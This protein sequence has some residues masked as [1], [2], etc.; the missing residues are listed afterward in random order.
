VT[1]A[2]LAHIVEQLGGR[3]VASIT[4]E[5]LSGERFELM[6]IMSGAI[7]TQKTIIDDGA[8]AVVVR[9]FEVIVD[10]AKVRV[11]HRRA[12]NLSELRSHV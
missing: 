6:Q 1:A 9:S 8:G 7:V 12:A 10:G 5:T 2:K 3:F 4:I 11:E